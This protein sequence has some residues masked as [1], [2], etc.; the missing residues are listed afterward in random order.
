M[1]GDRGNLYKRVDQLREVLGM[2]VGREHLPDLSGAIR[3][4]A[5][6]LEEMRLR[7]E[8]SRAYALDCRFA[9]ADGAA[10][11]ALRE[12]ERRFSAI[13]GA[14]PDVSALTGLRL[15]QIILLG[16]R[17]SSPHEAKSAQTPARMIASRKRI[18][19]LLPFHFLLQALKAVAQDSSS[20]P[21][22]RRRR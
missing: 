3:E 7:R 18:A 19:E 10:G 8:Q 20:S 22:A 12:P 14:Q 13:G 2:A 5:V 17:R 9:H 6:G 21:C 11:F 4:H 15:D 1:A 16:A